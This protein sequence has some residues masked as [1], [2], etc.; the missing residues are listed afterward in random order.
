VAIDPDAFQPGT[1][2]AGWSMLVDRLIDLDRTQDADACRLGMHLARA[3]TRLSRGSEAARVRSFVGT[4]GGPDAVVWCR[5]LAATIA[6]MGMTREQQTAC[7]KHFPLESR[8]PAF[9]DTSAW[10]SIFQEV[11]WWMTWENSDDAFTDA[12]D[13]AFPETAGGCFS[14]D[15]FVRVTDFFADHLGDQTNTEEAA[16]AV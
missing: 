14:L 5:R 13:R 2:L 7:L 16:A 12:F 11:K 4:L 6:F 15:F 3:L 1:D 9:G 10:E 8:I